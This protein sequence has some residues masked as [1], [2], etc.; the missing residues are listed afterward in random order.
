MWWLA[1]LVGCDDGGSGS[2]DGQKGEGA[3]SASRDCGATERCV[4]YGDEDGSC[5][6][7]CSVQGDDCGAQA[8]CGFIGSVSVSVCQ[9]VERLPADGEP[10]D[11]EDVPRLA[12]DTD[13]DCAVVGD[14]IVCAT[15][16]DHKGCT[17]LCED[18]EIC[19]PPPAGG[20]TLRFAVCGDDE[21]A[22]SRSVCIPNQECMADPRACFSGL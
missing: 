10:I 3:C 1:V 17:P 5:L 19:N 12:C 2:R 8:E 6:S 15:F 7:G 22:P 13:D 4:A 16:W 11:E 14:G 21:A 20:V 18:D 9:D